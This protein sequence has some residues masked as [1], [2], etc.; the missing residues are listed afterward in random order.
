MSLPHAISLHGSGASCDGPTRK[1]SSDMMMMRTV[2]EL[3]S[4]EAEPGHNAPPET[5]ERSGSAVHILELA[6][7]LRPSY[8]APGPCILSAVSGVTKGS[9]SGRKDHHQSGSLTASRHRC[10]VA[11]AGEHSPAS[12]T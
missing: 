2:E 7:L 8:E 5:A 9:E 4:G 1:A 12:V 11:P 3:P 10:C 6:F